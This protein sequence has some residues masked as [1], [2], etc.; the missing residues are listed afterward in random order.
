MKILLTGAAGN[1]GAACFASL[2][3]AGH[4]VVATDVS[5]K[6]GLPGRVKIGNLLAPEF[7]YEVAEDIECLVHLANLAHSGMGTPQRVFHENVTINMNVFQAAVDSGCRR[8]IF[9]SSIQAMGGSRR[10][11]DPQSRLAY[12]PIDGDSPQNPGNAYALSKCTGEMQVQYF[13]N[14][15]K[16]DEGVALRFPYLL[17]PHR[18]D[19]WRAQHPTDEVPGNTLMDEAFTWLSVNDAARLVQALVAKPMPGYRCYLPA[20]P[21]PRLNV[22]TRKLAESYFPGV[23]RRGDADGPLSDISRITQDTGW[24]PVDTLWP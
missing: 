21:Q 10:P 16:I 1:L 18:M 20:S 24:T 19:W 22:A 3:S 2:L 13:L 17:P 15:R 9:A 7:C 6:P 14:S 5:R 23:P 11:G 8:F 4:E 12:L